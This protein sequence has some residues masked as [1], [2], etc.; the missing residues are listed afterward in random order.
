MLSGSVLGSL[1]ESDLR[2]QGAQG[3]NLSKFCTA[4]AAGI[5]MSIVGKAFTTND[6]GT[7]T[8]NGTGIGTGISGLSASTMKGLALA[9]MFSRGSNADKMMQ[10]IMTAVVTHLSTS[11]QLSS[12]D[13]PVFHGTGVIVVGSMAV[14][15]SEMTANI[16]SQLQ[17]VGAR[18]SNRT[19]LSHAIAT[20]IC[21]NI[22]SSGTG[23][24]T[25]T[26]TQTSPV[27]SPGSGSGTGVIA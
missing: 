26:G 12:T 20:G 18:G 2:A 4:L 15:V 11:A 19:K 25:I 14:S 1:I 22:L 17:N 7:V 10:A 6:T 3:S 9:D 13:H 27:P 16:D 23:N 8:G 21:D 24:L 5:V